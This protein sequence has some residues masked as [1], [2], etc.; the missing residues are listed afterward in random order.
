M[1][2][3]MSQSDLMSAAAAMILGLTI[4]LTARAFFNSL[5]SRLRHIPTV[6]GSSGLISSY[7]S[8][9]RFYF[10]GQLMIQEGYEKYPDSVFKIATMSRWWVFVSGRELIDDIRRATDNNMSFHGAVPELMQCDYT[11]GPRTHEDPYHGF[12]A[13]VPLSKRL[14]KHYLEIHEEVILAFDN[15]FQMQNH[16]ESKS[17]ILPTYRIAAQTILR[18]TG[19]LLVGSPLCEN[20]DYL[21]LGQTFM[22][23]V[24]ILSQ[25]MNM[26]PKLLHPILGRLVS[27]KVSRVVKLAEPHIRR[28]AEGHMEQVMQG[29]ET[30]SSDSSS[31]VT[32]LIDEAIKSQRKVDFDDLTRRTLDLSFVAMG[33]MLSTFSDVLLNLATHPEFVAPMREEVLAV[34]TEE[35][36]TKIA[37]GKMQKVDSFI[38]ETLRLGLGFSTGSRKIFKD[39]TL[40]NGITLPAGTFVSF[41]TC[42]IQ[43]DE[44]HYRNPHEFQ[45][46]R[47][48]ETAAEE[49]SDMTNQFVSLSPEFLAFGIGRHACPGRFFASYTLKVALAHVL[50]NF[51]VKF[52]DS[53]SSGRPTKF[54]F[55]AIAYPD[56]KTELILSKRT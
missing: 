18:A 41:P 31:L 32:W 11:I 10:H 13:G 29:D 3:K 12:F 51:D 30:E 16:A 1:A 24:I 23:D 39:F 6:G 22:R 15:L 28:I 21:Q 9:L 27:I 19:R 35:G 42:A 38:K 45:G 50:L 56:A 25:A 53:N 44:R 5:T 52:L 20:T 40:S 54:W 7:F 36:W 49:R 48:V 2:G 55:Q 47:F 34:T 8:S 37:V 33:T 4:Y 14:A 17:L 46:F 26:F 43:L